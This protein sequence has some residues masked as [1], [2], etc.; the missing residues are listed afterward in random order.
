MSLQVSK[1]GPAVWGAG[2]QAPIAPASEVSLDAHALGLEACERFRRSEGH[3]VFPLRV[4]WSRSVRDS[5]YY[6][7]EL[8]K[9]VRLR[10]HLRSY[11]D[12][13]FRQQ[14]HV[15]GA[16]STAIF[17][18]MPHFQAAPWHLRYVAGV[19][20]E[21][22]LGETVYDR[23]HDFDSKG[24]CD[25]GV[26]H[27]RCLPLSGLMT[28]GAAHCFT[29]P[30]FWRMAQERQMTD[31]RVSATRAPPSALIETHARG[32]EEDAEQAR[33]HVFYAHGLV[34]C[35]S[36]VIR[37]QLSRWVARP[38][39]HVPASAQPSSAPLPDASTMTPV[40][41]PATPHPTPLAGAAAPALP[42]PS[43]PA[44]AAPADSGAPGR[45]PDAKD[46]S[47]VCGAVSPGAADEAGAGG[48]LLRW[49]ISPLGALL[50]LRAL[51]AGGPEAGWRSHTGATHHAS[52]ADPPIHSVWAEVFSFAHMY[53]LPQ[54]E[55]AAGAI[56]GRHLSA[57]NVLPFAKLAVEHEGSAIH[58]SLVTFVAANAA[59]FVSAIVPLLVAAPVSPS[60]DGL[61]KGKRRRV[62]ADDPDAA[63]LADP[64]SSP[65]SRLRGPAHRVPGAD[66]KAP[67]IAADAKAPTI[68]AAPVLPPATP[69]S[70]LLA[71]P[72]PTASPFSAHPPPSVWVGP[73]DE[74]FERALFSRHGSAPAPSS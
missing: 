61:A 11:E 28:G 65:P 6:L 62:A 73:L 18:Q 29:A 46:G 43:S 16:T 74:W 41:A 4:G 25:T 20:N 57:A 72:V 56:L 3:W 39:T 67:T 70:H 1:E 58:T 69:S 53:D 66:V 7:F 52:W 37:A 24:I 49:H 38:R 21:S 33:H 9:T 47:E 45:C 35:Q 48:V 64:P 59:S 5:R 22:S 23:W 12:G 63:T 71:H 31:V 19:Q 51:Y 32:L 54:I 13:T 30:L 55:Q 60:A 36:E 40:S 50:V 14:C 68:S 10:V 2:A 17:V 8:S 34:L 44:G 26:L 15:S 42:D 27:V